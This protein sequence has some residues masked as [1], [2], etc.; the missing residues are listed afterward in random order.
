LRSSGIPAAFKDCHHKA[1][2]PATWGQAM[3]V[4]LILFSPPPGQ[5]EVMSTPGADK[6]ARL[7]EKS[8]TA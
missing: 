8:A 2:T 5:A 4:P 3:L 6:T 7:L 1:A